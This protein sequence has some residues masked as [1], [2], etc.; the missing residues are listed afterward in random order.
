VSFLLLTRLPNS[1]IAGAGVIISYICTGDFT[2]VPAIIWG[3]L[4]FIF[5][6]MGGYV[7]N[8]LAD[9]ATDKHAHP[10]RPLVKGTVSTKTASLLFPCLYIL[11][12]VAACF[13][14]P[15]HGVLAAGVILLLWI[16]NVYLKSRVLAGNLVVSLLCGLSLY[17]AECPAPVK[18]TLVPVVFSVLTTFI[19]E[20]IK[21]I[22]DRDGDIKA[23]MTTLPVKYGIRAAKKTAGIL[24]VLVLFLLPFPM[25]YFDYHYSFG[26]AAFFLVVIPL[27]RAFFQIRSPDPQW[28]S[29]QKNVKLLMLGGMVALV[30]GKIL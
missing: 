3:S 25:L 10:D 6:A 29:A 30:L 26:I 17:Y 14:S 11:G 20:I 24:L 22:Q 16:Y 7:Q 4:S 13:T 19:R 2:S 5:L 18:L 28:A 8:D 1:L 9:L 21:D 12:L 23:G 27:F 15:A